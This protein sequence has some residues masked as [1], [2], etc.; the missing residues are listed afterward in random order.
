MNADKAGHFN[1]KPHIVITDMKH[2]ELL[3]SDSDPLFYANLPKGHYIIEGSNKGKTQSQKI[4]VTGK[5]TVR[6]HF[7]W[8]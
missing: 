5:K 4:N 2:R 6:V 8:K 3:N 1:G 7:V